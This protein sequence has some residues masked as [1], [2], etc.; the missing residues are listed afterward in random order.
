MSLTMYKASVPVFVREL[1]IL[2][3]L[4]KK[5]EDFAKE[6]GFS[7]DALVQERLAED[8]LPLAGQIQRASDACKL[9]VERLTGVA[10]PK[11][12]DDETSYAQ[13]YQRIEKTLAYLNSVPADAFSEAGVREVKLNYGEFQPV[14]TGES[15]LLTFAIPNFFFHVVTAY[16]ILRHKGVPI[17]KRDYLG[18]Y[19]A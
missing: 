16:D 13:L 12:D 10:A 6:K 19:S 15:Y 7:P 4:L 5:G 17:G 2:S 14:F 3:S 1:G 8:M 18:P 9:A 11:F